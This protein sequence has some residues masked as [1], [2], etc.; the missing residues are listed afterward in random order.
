M[1]FD[2]SVLTDNWYLL[3]EGLGTTVLICALA[4]PLGFI[5]GVVLALMRLSGIRPLPTI[6]IGYVEIVRNVP[7][8][9]QIYLLFFGLP[10]LG[11]RIDALLL[12]VIALAV[13]ASAYFAEIV[14][15]AVLSVPDGQHDAATALGLPFLLIY[16]KVILPQ[17]LGYLI[18]ASTNL[19][20]TLIKESAVLSVITVAELTYMSQ[21]IIGR[22]FAPVEVF[23]AIALIYWALTATVAAILRHFEIRVERVGPLSMPSG[24]GR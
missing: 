8:L 16:R 14:R 4:L 21:F 13:Y 12:A 3:A 10:F 15:G 20:I 17:T 18:P 1:S 2:V 23:T 22:T 7:F 6:V 11:I 19:A 9:I 24:L 5:A